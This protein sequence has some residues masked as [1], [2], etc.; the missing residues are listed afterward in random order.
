MRTFQKKLT[1]KQRATH[2]QTLV[3]MDKV[4]NRYVEKMA[5]KG[6]KRDEE[7][8]EFAGN[9]FLKYETIITMIKS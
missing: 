6:W 1:V 5:A 3:A 7:A 8:T 4:I 9:N 2:E